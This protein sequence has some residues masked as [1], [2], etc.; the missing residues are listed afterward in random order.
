MPTTIFGAASGDTNPVM[1]LR[2]VNNGSPLRKLTIC[3]IPSMG[4]ST[5]QTWCESSTCDSNDIN[6]VPA[7]STSAPK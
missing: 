1:T 6:E 3:E 4:S 5:N 2:T 7:H